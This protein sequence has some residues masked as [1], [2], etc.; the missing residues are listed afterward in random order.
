M[1]TKNDKKFIL[2]TV[3]ESTTQNNKILIKEF[4]DLFSSTNERIDQINEKLSYK[5]DGTNSRVDK[6][7]H[8]FKNHKL[9]IYTTTTNPQ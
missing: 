3:R 7:L 4:V 5:I 1:L 6:V 2:E 9:N 8:E